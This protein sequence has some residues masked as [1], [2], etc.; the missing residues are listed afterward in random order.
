MIPGAGH[1]VR[2]EAP[3]PTQQILLERFKPETM[4]RKR[5]RDGLQDM[6]PGTRCSGHCGNIMSFASMPWS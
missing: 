5:G 4:P 2:F 1:W 6:T 3:E